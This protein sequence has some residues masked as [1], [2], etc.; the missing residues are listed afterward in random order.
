MNSLNMTMNRVTNVIENVFRLS[1][2][3]PT[4]VRLQ[5]AM[6]CV[7][8]LEKSWLTPMQLAKLI[9]VFEHE[10]A[11]AVAYQSMKDSE[12]LRKSWVCMKIHIPVPEDEF[13]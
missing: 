7:M 13:A 10:P 1:T 9:D 5:D 4:P 11:A 3:P 6:M 12:D 8:K 2:L